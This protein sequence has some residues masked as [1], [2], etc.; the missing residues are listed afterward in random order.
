MIPNPKKEAKKSGYVYIPSESNNEPV[1]KQSTCE[2]HEYDIKFCIMVL[3]A[4]LLILVG[5]LITNLINDSYKHK[6]YEYN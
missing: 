3:F 6:K 4:L 5:T 1:P 2:R